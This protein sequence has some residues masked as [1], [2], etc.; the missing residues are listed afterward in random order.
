MEVEET[1]GCDVGIGTK[2]L[3]GVKDDGSGDIV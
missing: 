1:F 3:I 2:V